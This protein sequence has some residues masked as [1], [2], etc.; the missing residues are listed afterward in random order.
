MTTSEPAGSPP[1]EV[2]RELAPG[3]VLRVA[4]NLG[5]PVLAQR[6]PATGALGGASVDLAREVGR[7]LGLPVTLVSFDAAGKVVAAAT[8]GAWDLAFLA[9]DPARAAELRF[10]PPYVVIEGTYLV[11]E[12]SP[13]RAIEDLD[14]PGVR[15]AVGRGAAYELHL[16][17]ALRHATL[18]RSDT[19]AGA[20]ELFLREGLEAAA[21]V[22]NPLVAFA[23]AH[24]GLRVLPGRFTV[25][26]Q[27]LA[28]PRGREVAGRW[29]DAFVE[30][31]KASGFVA[32]ALARSG[33]RDAAVAPPAPAR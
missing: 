31:V 3:G 30:E 29:L 2:A 19:S 14:R 15:I 26:E 23:A 24:P 4:I 11:P 16:T 18:V 1:A 32:A 13:L 12:A 33:Q 28:A 10:T 7:R 27:A 17:R 22:R 9:R 25:I 21:G 8:T 6:E 20:V 5:N